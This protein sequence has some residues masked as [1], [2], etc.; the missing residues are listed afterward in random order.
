VKQILSTIALLII[1]VL[2]LK[3]QSVDFS[4]PYTNLINTNPANIGTNTCPRLYINSR[5]KNFSYDQ[6]FQT[7]YASYDQAIRKWN[8]D[9]GIVAL[10]DENGNQL[11]T[12]HSIHPIIGKAIEIA[13]GSIIKLA[14]QAD[15]LH[16]NLGNAESTYPDMID[17]QYGF[18]YPTSEPASSYSKFS[19]GA[20][21]GLLYY[22]NTFFLG[23]ATHNIIPPKTG[24]SKS[25]TH[26]PRKFTFSLGYQ[27]TATNGMFYKNN[28]TITPALYV[29]QESKYN[30]GQIG[31]SAKYQN[32]IAG[33]FGRISAFS[34]F[35]SFCPMIGFHQKRF[36]FAYTC[37]LH[38]VGRK[39]KEFDT[40]E[41]SLT[42]YLP[43]G[44]YS[45]RR[46]SIDC[47]GH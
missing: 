15:L 40:H 44:D 45:P 17:Q 29:T 10:R 33:V 12:T 11:F 41:V 20:S 22:T 35:D 46:R 37:D 25:H 42:I 38:T 5:T 7:Y 31:F 1:S 30:L 4:Q 36:K 47:P 34:S 3:S 13:S 32:Y 24:N 21:A 28:V 9:F 23:I 19:A 27:I 8:L 39:K 18:I 43:C 16:L 6:K 14:L 26:F 2:A